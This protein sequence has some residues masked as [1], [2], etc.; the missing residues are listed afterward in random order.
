MSAFQSSVNLAMGFAVPG[1]LFTNAP[2]KADSYILNSAS[3]AYNIIGATAFT[4]SA[5]GVAAAGNATTGGV[6]AGILANPKTAKSVGTS[7]GG[8]LAPT[9]TLQNNEQGEVV[10]MGDLTVTLPAAA[11]I[12]DKVWYDNTTGALGTV[13]PIAT[14]TASIATTVLTV[15]V[16]G[17]NSAPLAVGQIVT[18]A[19]ITP[20]TYIT[21]LGSGTGG[22]GTYTVSI[23]Q[24]AA[25]A[26]VTAD[27]VAPSGKTLC[28][29]TFVAKYNP[30]GAGIAVISLL[31]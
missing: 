13:P 31:N 1:E 19:N 27:S 21:A 10:R 18:G 5:E 26:T 20:G 2:H 3:A 15:T 4:V 22:A 16:V 6:F 23:S 28:P 25:S 24:T 7:G 12:G 30:A 14:V 17:T 29:R 9:L 8:T 11:T